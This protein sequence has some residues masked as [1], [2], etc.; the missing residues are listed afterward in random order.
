[1]AQEQIG[2]SRSAPNLNNEHVSALGNRQRF[3]PSAS[4]SRSPDIVA[5]CFGCKAE[6]SLK[7]QKDRQERG[8]TAGLMRRPHQQELLNRRI[9]QGGWGLTCPEARGSLGSARGTFT[10]EWGRGAAGAGQNLDFR[11]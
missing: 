1:M 2:Y 10:G 7:M 8:L 6:A 11:M 3:N 4:C 5:S 9:S